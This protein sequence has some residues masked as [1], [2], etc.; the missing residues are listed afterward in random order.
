MYECLTNRCRRKR[1]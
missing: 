1:S